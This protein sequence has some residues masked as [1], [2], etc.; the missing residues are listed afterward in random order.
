MRDGEGSTG[1]VPWEGDLGDHTFQSF[2][3]VNG[4]EFKRIAL[5]RLLDTAA[6]I[7]AT[8]SIDPVRYAGI[9]PIDGV[10]MAGQPARARRDGAWWLLES[11][12]TGTTVIETTQ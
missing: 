12:V 2:A 8:V 7:G 4:A 3:R 5:T 11:D 1:S 6:A 9:Y 10:L